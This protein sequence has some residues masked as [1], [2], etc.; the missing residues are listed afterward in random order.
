VA[1]TGGAGGGEK[2]KK[3]NRN[4]RDD[5]VKGENRQSATRL[6][7]GCVSFPST[8]ASELIDATVAPLRHAIIE[9]IILVK[10]AHVIFEALSAAS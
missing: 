1:R 4:R 9:E 2:K 7:C 6:A 3:K 8:N 5:R 10:L